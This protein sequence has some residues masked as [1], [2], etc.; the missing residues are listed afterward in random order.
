MVWQLQHNPRHITQMSHQSPPYH[1]HPCKTL[2]CECEL[3][4]MTATKQTHTLA[5]SHAGS[6]EQHMTRTTAFVSVIRCML[7]DTS[8]LTSS[9]NTG[10]KKQRMN[11]RSRS[12]QT[13]RMHCPTKKPA[14]TP[15]QFI[16]EY[17]CN[18]WQCLPAQC[19][20]FHCLKPL[21]SIE[22][23]T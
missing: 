16:T 19:Q 9:R 11:C 20:S 1:M 5:S 4:R 23:W 12:W 2:C 8:Y 3:Q 22:H 13:C 6:Y 15:T 14:S 21:Y 10:C 18:C 7:R 17:C